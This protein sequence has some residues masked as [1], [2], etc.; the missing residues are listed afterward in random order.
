VAYLTTRR[1]LPA[2]TVA[3]LMAPA[4]AAQAP[5]PTPPPAVP[6][7]AAVSLDHTCYAPGDAII[8]TGRG[9]A[10]NA[11]ILEVVA[12]FAP[13]GTGDPLRTLGATLTSDASGSFTLGLRAPQLTRQSDRTEDALSLF[14]DPNPVGSPTPPAPPSVE[15]TLSARDIKIAQWVN[16]VGDP[17]RSMTVDTYGWTGGRSA[18]YAHYYRGTTRIRSVKVGALTGA[19][20]NL[21]KQLKQFPFKRVKA[22]E[23]RVFFSTTPVLDKQRDIWLRKTVIVPQSKATA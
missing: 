23:W 22:G 16:R 4:A 18:V 14:T 9:F 13:G 15:W 8:H 10:P 20:G 6:P 12:F 21:R 5:P 2:A 17:A 3:L 1:A 7:G 11:Q 19:C